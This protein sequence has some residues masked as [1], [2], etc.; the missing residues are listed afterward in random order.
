MT[1]GSG[2]AGPKVVQVHTV[3]LYEPDGGRV[4]HV[5]QVKVFE[6]GKSVDRETAEREA[7]EQARKRGHDVDGLRLHYTDRSLPMKR[8]LL[9][10]DRNNGDLTT[11]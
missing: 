11:D 3:A 4:A 10:F 1:H 9:R 5:H 8:G 2:G 6:G 7:V